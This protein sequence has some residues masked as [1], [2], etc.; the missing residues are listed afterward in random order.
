M[1]C[2]LHGHKETMTA[3]GRIQNIYTMKVINKTSHDLPVELKLENVPGGVRLM[4]FGSFLIPK[5]KQGQTSVLIELDPAAL[6]GNSTQL[7]LGVYANGKRLET[8]TT[9]FVGP[10]R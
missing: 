7:K 9:G 8:V 1:C 2:T 4:G 3:E 5:E 6:T 10:R